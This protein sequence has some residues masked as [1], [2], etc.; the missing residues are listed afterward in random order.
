MISVI[1]LTDVSIRRKNNGYE[2]TFCCHL[3]HTKNPHVFP[4]HLTPYE[5]IENSQIY[6]YLM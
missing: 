5:C 1:I 6:S 2:Y 4:S 3:L